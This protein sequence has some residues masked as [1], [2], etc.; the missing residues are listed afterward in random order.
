MGQILYEEGHSV[1][2]LGISAPAL[3]VFPSTLDRGRGS[4]HPCGLRFILGLGLH[5]L[6]FLLVWMTTT[7]DLQ[8]TFLNLSLH[9]TVSSLPGSFTPDLGI[10]PGR[11]RSYFHMTNSAYAPS[12]VRNIL[13]D[14]HQTASSLP[15]ISVRPTTLSTLS[16][17]Y[18]AVVERPVL[19]LRPSQLLS[20]PF[21]RGRS[22]ASYANKDDCPCYRI[23][24]WSLGFRFTT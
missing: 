7:Q 16:G 11:F 13:P 20:G 15:D 22:Y 4:L 9:S 12:S 8:P 19:C 21:G 23:S 17:R 3:R 10:C 2:L 6:S 5:S 24:P 14:T 18:D 1:H